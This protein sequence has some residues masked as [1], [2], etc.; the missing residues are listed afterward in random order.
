MALN[1]GPKVVVEGDNLGVVVSGLPGVQLERQQVLAVE[2]ELNGREIRK[3]PHEQAG[4][5]QN[6]EGEGDLRDHQHAAQAEAAKPV[7]ARFAG[8]RFL[9]RRHDVRP[10]RLE[11]RSKPEQHARQQREPG[12]DDQHV[13]VQFRAQG[14]VLTSIRQQQRQETDA[15]D[16]EHDTQRAAEHGEQDALGE[17][18]ADDPKPSGPQTQAECDFAPAGG[19]ARQEEVG[20]V[21]ARDAEDEAHQRQED[22][23]RLRIGPPQAVEAARAF[24]HEQSGNVVRP[25]LRARGARPF[26]ERADQPPPVPATR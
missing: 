10:R 17:E 13:P 23:E 25:A 16:G 20:D 5:D 19:R 9:E 7:P 26:G 3:R 11:R 21:R 15:P 22:V 8:S 1:C 24:P 6:Q 4:R 2:S 18:L 12:H 14:E